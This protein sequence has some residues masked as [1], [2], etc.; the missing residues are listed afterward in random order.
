M[1]LPSVDELPGQIY[2]GSAAVCG[3]FSAAITAPLGVINKKM[4]SGQYKSM[5]E[6]VKITA[7]NEGYR[8]FFQ[9]LGS[10]CVWMASGLALTMFACKR[11]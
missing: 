3:T 9:G 4:Q 6:A 10:R 11:I 5:L 7:R 1:N 2:L 8:T